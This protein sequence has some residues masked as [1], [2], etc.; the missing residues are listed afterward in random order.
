MGSYA[1]RPICNKYFFPSA[2]CFP[3]IDQ[4]MFYK[5]FFPS[6]DF[7]IISVGLIIRKST[8]SNYFKGIWSYTNSISKLSWYDMYTF[9]EV[10]G[11]QFFGPIFW[12]NFLDPKFFGPKFFETIYWT[13]FLDQF[14][15]L[16]DWSWGLI[17]RILRILRIDHENL[18]DLEDW[19]WEYWGS[20]GSILR[21][22]RILRW[23][24][25]SVL[26]RA[27]ALDQFFGSIFWTFIYQA[28]NEEAT[29]LTFPVGFWIQ[30]I[31]FQL[32]F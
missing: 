11:S 7:L 17:L 31:F 21:L 16:E 19:S 1:T 8:E 9:R 10:L 14:K 15:N 2:H 27:R 29:F 6:F 26:I 18:E 25:Q 22:L 13:N 20:W 4:F 24:T 3:V 23:Y 5:Y 32:E 28:H 12:T 30:I